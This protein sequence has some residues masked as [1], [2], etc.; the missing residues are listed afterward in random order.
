MRREEIVSEPGPAG[1]N[2]AAIVL[3][4]GKSRRMKTD[5]CFLD[6]HGIPLIESVIDRLAANFPAVII[7]SN[8][9]DKFAFLG[10]P[11]VVD[12]SPYGGPPAGILAGLKS[13]PYALNFITA[14]DIPVISW[15]LIRSL[16]Q[17]IGNHDVALPSRGKNLWEPFHGVY[18]R[19]LIPLLEDVMRM[20]TYWMRTVLDSADVVS[21]EV[22]PGEWPD[23]LNTPEEYQAFIHS[24]IRGH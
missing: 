18:R 13:S 10:V 15:N 14:C 5:K 12:D 20:K 1:F 9:P 11:I 4:G 7:S 22:D 6:V 16:F 2:A 24:R 19:R 23:N 3:A 8:E 17:C 21:V